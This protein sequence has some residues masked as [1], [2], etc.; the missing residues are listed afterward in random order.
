MLRS[1]T[2]DTNV[3]YGN[4]ATEHDI[5]SIL[6][7]AAAAEWE[8]FQFKDETPT[9]NVTATKENGS[10]AFD[11]V[12]SFYLPKMQNDKFHILQ[13]LLTTCMMGIVLDTNGKY[14]VIGVSEKY[15]VIDNQH[16]NQTYLN[17]T[18]MEGQTGA[19]YSEENGITVVLTARQYELPRE[20]VGTVVVNTGTLACTTAA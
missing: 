17:L 7:L 1:W 12:L 14:W 10:T 9:L 3:V 8:L 5:D 18:S 6:E 4:A 15:S 11:C 16:K 20:Y 19:A 2:S 13:E